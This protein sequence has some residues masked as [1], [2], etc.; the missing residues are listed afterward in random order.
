MAR[1]KK[2]LRIAAFVIFQRVRN[3]ALSKGVSGLQHCAMIQVSQSG[4][5]DVVLS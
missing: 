4:N 1:C 2:D 5:I 3:C